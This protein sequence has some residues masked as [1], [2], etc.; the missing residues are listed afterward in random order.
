VDADLSVGGALHGTEGER[1]A[2]EVAADA[3]E[4]LS[5]AAVNRDRCVQLHAEGRDEHRFY[6]TGLGA[7]GGP[8]RAGPA[9]AQLDAGRDALL[10][11]FAFVKRMLGEVGVQTLQ[12]AQKV[13]PSQLLGGPEVHRLRVVIRRV[14]TGGLEAPVG[15]IPGCSVLLVDRPC[16]RLLCRRSVCSTRLAKRRHTRASKRLS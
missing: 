12:R 13:V 6:G 16:S 8:G 5:V 14:A 1:R 11:R 9:Q 2:Q 4:S 10:G 15:H 3:F 7:H